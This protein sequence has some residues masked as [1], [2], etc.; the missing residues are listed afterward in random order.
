MPQTVISARSTAW[1]NGAVGRAR[2]SAQ[3]ELRRLD[4]DDVEQRAI[5]E[6]RRQKGVLDHFGIGDADIFRDQE[7][8][9][10]HHRRHQLAVDAGGASIAPA[11]TAE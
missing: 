8:R 11:F 10:A 5:G 1:C 4:I 9:G 7:R 2:Q 3:A 6:E